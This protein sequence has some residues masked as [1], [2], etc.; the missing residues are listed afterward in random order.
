VA[1]KLHQF[2]D[3]DIKR[4]IKVARAEGI[5]PTAVEVNPATG[6][7]KVTGSKAAPEQTNLDRELAEFQE[8]HGEV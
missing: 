7:I 2:K 1:N 8:R 5:D 4:V 3:R 6:A